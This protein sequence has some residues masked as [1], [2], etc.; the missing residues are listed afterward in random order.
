M[1][2]RTLRKRAVAKLAYALSCRKT[3]CV[4]LELLTDEP[5]FLQFAE[6]VF[7][8]VLCEPM[9]ETQREAAL[10]WHR[11][12]TEMKRFGTAVRSR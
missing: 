10:F 3:I 2:L 12:Y 9:T 6:H 8:D 11:Q 4:P 5:V 1:K 7:D